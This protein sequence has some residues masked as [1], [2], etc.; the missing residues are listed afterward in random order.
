ME[1]TFMAVDQYGQ[2]FHGLEHPRK[3]LTERLG[4][5][6]VDKMFHDTQDGNVEHI[7]YVIGGHWCRVYTVTPWKK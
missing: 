3:D 5:Q 4:C 6:H 2:T 7:G 1:A